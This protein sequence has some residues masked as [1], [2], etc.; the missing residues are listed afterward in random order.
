MSDVTEEYDTYDYH[1]RRDQ[2][3]GHKNHRAVLSQA[4]GSYQAANTDNTV[5]S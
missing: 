2:H 4:Q 3:A 5:K 1:E